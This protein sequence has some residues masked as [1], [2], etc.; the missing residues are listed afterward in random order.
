MVWRK[1]VKDI[2]DPAFSGGA[3]LNMNKCRIL[4]ANSLEE[5]PVSAFISPF[6]N[7]VTAL[8]SS[9]SVGLHKKGANLTHLRYRKPLGKVLLYFLLKRKYRQEDTMLVVKSKFNTKFHLIKPFL[10]RCQAKKNFEGLQC[11]AILKID[12]C[13]REWES[14][15]PELCKARA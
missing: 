3:K 7:G 13:L 6:Y 10:D 5:A 15:K 12:D 9:P 2:A 14:L 4:T 8:G 1:Q 11:A